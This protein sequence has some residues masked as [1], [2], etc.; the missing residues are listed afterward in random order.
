MPHVSG[1]LPLE[2][3]EH[4]RARHLYMLK[5]LADRGHALAM[6]AADKAETQLNAPED[7]P[8]SAPDHHR[9]YERYARL[10]RLLVTAEHRIVN[11]THPTRRP[12]R[13]V[14]PDAD[15]R[16]PQ[17][18]QFLH[19]ATRSSPERAQLRRAALDTLDQ[20]LEQDPARTRPPGDIL[21]E[22]CQQ[23]GL[24]FDIAHLPDDFLDAE[25]ESDP[26]ADDG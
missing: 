5:S 18:R 25:P 9:T 23:Y 16:H 8:P 22:I 26:K 13:A 2:P 15:P 10:V 12:Y 20:A 19:Q 6:K 11:Q 1:A 21:F 17:L 14:G 24:P 7:P 3:E 4:R